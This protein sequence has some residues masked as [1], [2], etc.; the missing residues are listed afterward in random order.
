MGNASSS[1]RK[2]PDGAISS[3]VNPRVDAT[4]NEAKKAER[5]LIG[6]NRVYLMEAMQNGDHEY[7]LAFNEMMRVLRRL[8][9]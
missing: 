2:Q 7:M 5:A 9:E 3:Y 4:M 6:V 1:S 8:Q